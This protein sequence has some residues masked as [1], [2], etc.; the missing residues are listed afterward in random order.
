VDRLQL[1][2]GREAGARP[3]H[4][5]ERADGP[6]REHPE[7]TLTFIGDIYAVRLFALVAARLGLDR[8]K[9]EIEAKLKTLDDIYGFAVE[10]SSMARGSFWS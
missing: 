2:Q 7:N 10:Q 6:D 5:R 9:A 3:G 8:W 1:R 4:R